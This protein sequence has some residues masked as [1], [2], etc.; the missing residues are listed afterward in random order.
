MESSARAWLFK[1]TIVND[2][3]TQVQVKFEG[4]L[5]DLAK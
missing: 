2:R 1:S 3:P 4:L 5:K